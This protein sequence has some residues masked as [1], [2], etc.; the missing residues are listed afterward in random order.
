MAERGIE[1]NPDCGEC[2]L[3]KFSSMGRL[4][5]TRD[6]W[7]AGRQLP[8]M[9]A[10]LDRGIALEPSY[11]DNENNSVLGNLHY[12]SAI[13]Y[14]IL[15]DWIFLKWFFGV[16]GDKERSLRHIKT[17]LSLH[18]DRLEYRVELGSQLLCLGTSKKD[19]GRLERGLEV[20]R[21]AVKADPQ[22]LR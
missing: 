22:S 13:F 14:R 6:I 10:L 18:P 3:W 16:R 19:R 21:E 8:I 4:A 12:S 5:T 17:A 11:A 1:A 20:L 7:S 9:A 2:M 15:P